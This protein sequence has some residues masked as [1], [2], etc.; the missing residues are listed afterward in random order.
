MWRGRSDFPAPLHECVVVVLLVE[1]TNHPG[2]EGPPTGLD[3]PLLVAA[4]AV[5]LL[6]EDQARE[7]YDDGDEVHNHCAE[8]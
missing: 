1:G 8:R 5:L 3:G 6:N 4:A 2:G 7:V